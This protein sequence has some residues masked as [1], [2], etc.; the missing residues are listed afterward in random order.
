MAGAVDGI[1][2]AGAAVVAAEKRRFAVVYLA[3][4]AGALA[5][6]LL[7]Q[8]LELTA[9]TPQLFPLRFYQQVIG[10]LDGRSCPSWPVC[11]HYAR[12]AVA[13]H[14][15]LLGSWMALDRIIH[16]SD[17]LHGGPTILV[18]GERRL[19]DPLD[20]NDFWIHRGANE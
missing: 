8:R 3:M 7:W 14:G 5:G 20:R 10:Q 9:S 17:D 15:W 12:E 11:S 19:Y 6:A 18:A 13:R 1:G 4:A 2:I 16:E